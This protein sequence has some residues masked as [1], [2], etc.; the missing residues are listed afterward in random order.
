MHTPSSQVSLAQLERLVRT[1]PDPQVRRR[2]QC[3][4]VLESSP[5][6][7]AA[8]HAVHVSISTLRRWQ[9]RFRTDGR[10]GLADRPR[11]GRPRKLDAA[12]ERTLTEML[13][14]M[15]TDHGY[16]TASWTLADLRDVLMRRGWEVS[17]S[18]VIRTMQHLGYRYRRPR[19]DLRHRQDA[20]TVATARHTLDV[21]RKK[22]VLT[23]EEYDS[24]ISTSA[25]FIH[26]PTWQKSGNAEVIHASSR[27][28]ASINGSRSSG[29]SST[30]QES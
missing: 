18:T 12:A 30:G 21:L 8:S 1:D 29:H 9:A 26:I 3:L 4:I 10:D 27:R 2:A 15:P 11:P 19:H 7:S 24:C 14:T 25:T 28:L 5:T 20:D 6:W 22:G 16:A 23:T 13:V 17:M